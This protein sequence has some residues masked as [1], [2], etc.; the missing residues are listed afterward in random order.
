MIFFQT[1]D[2]V[3]LA[4]ETEFESIYG[5]NYFFTLMARFGLI[6][7]SGFYSGLFLFS[8]S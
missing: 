4:R 3:E 2:L 5:L 1:L 7:R 6:G 8:N